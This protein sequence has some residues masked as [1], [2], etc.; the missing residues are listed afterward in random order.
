MRLDYGSC[1]IQSEWVST[2]I[3]K[4]HPIETLLLVEKLQ[5][6]EQGRGY[7]PDEIL[8]HVD[9]SGFAPFPAGRTNAQQPTPRC[10]I[11]PPPE[12]GTESVK[13]PIIATGSIMMGQPAGMVVIRDPIEK[14]PTPSPDRPTTCP[15]ASLPS[16]L[17]QD[18]V[19]A[20]IYHHRRH[21]P[22]HTILADSE[23]AR[24]ARQERTS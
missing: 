16:G 14:G 9:P 7:Q 19:N 13:N 3:G 20:H 4:D 15:G 12:C 10:F 1:P 6:P 21:R 11:E 22:L 18:V 8:P 17:K 2:T 5:I 24:S 23:I